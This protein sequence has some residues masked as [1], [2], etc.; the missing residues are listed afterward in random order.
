MNKFKEQARRP[1][2]LQSESKIFLIDEKSAHKCELKMTMVGVHVN[3]SALSQLPF[4]ENNYN[5]G[6]KSIVWAKLVLQ[7]FRLDL[8][9]IHQIFTILIVINIELL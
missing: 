5:T 1:V 9:F 4:H 7:I 2:S 3:Y 8:N 6:Q